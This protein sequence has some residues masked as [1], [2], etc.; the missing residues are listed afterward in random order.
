V[1]RV[2]KAHFSRLQR[3]QGDS[4][5]NDDDDDDDEDSDGGVGLP[6]ESPGGE[7][8]LPEDTEDVPPGVGRG[9]G[10]EVEVHMRRP[11]TDTRADMNPSDGSADVT[12][13]SSSRSV[14]RNKG[15]RRSGGSIEQRSVDNGDHQ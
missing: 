8:V 13:D 12:G 4:L 7:K 5:S 11:G 6:S 10:E 9:V 14:S 2:R 3:Q 1:R 15:G